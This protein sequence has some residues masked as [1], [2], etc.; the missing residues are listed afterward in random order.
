[1]N[2]HSPGTWIVVLAAL[3][4]VVWLGRQ[5]VAGVNLVGRRRRAL[6]FRTVGSTPEV[7][8]PRILGV[9]SGA[10]WDEVRSV[11]RCSTTW[12]A[13]RPRSRRSQSRCLGCTRTA[14]R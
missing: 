3:A 10:S 6:T 2:P 11:P 9:R 13:T 5:L 8:V 12:I 7:V 4:V 14:T 1:M